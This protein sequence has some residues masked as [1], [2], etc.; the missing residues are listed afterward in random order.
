M[1]KKNKNVVGVGFVKDVV[2]AI[3]VVDDEKT[4]KIWKT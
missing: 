3:I 4:M 1:V 2:V